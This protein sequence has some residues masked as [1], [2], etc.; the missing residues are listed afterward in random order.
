PQGSA[1]RCYDGCKVRDTCPY[2]AEKIYITGPIGIIADP[3]VGWPQTVVCDN[4][5]VETLTEALK[6]GPYGRCV[7][8]CD[9]NVVDHQS[10]NMRMDN[11]MTVSFTMS[12]FAAKVN[13][14]I[15]I[16]GTMGEISGDMENRHITV[17]PFI[18]EPREI[19]LETL[20]DDFTGHGGGDK[21]ML[22]EFAA[23]LSGGSKK[24]TS[25]TSISA[26]LESHY[27]ALAAEE[28]RLND[29]ERV[30]MSEFK[31]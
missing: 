8:H 28:S 21:R 7:Y 22:A 3:K 6:T 1:M 31:K 13:R 4:P 17:S 12:A 11:N 27:V 5:T 30:V 24:D 23:V 16:M 29:G 2:D 25:L 15:R 14:T 26:S 10:V 20:P 9:N 19:E 18:G